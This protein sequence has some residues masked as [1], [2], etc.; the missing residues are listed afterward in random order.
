MP[1][2]AAYGVRR[3]LFAEN[4]STGQA[5]GGPER[6]PAGVVPKDRLADVP[7]SP[8]LFLCGGGGGGG[9]CCCC[10]CCCCWDESELEAIGFLFS[11]V[12]MYCSRRQIIASL[13]FFLWIFDA[14]RTA[15]SKEKKR[16]EKEKALLQLTF[17]VFDGGGGGGL[18]LPLPMTRTSRCRGCCCFLSSSTRTDV[19]TYTAHCIRTCDLQRCA[20][21]YSMPPFLIPFRPFQCDSIQRCCDEKNKEEATSDAFASSHLASPRL[22]ASSGSTAAAAAFLARLQSPQ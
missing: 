6:S 19:C 21:L 16:E 22:V 12:K 2:R 14:R 7:L 4:N 11:F 8:L 3:I 5:D 17:V 18:L 13:F 9:C 15:K 1:C 20:F 10:C